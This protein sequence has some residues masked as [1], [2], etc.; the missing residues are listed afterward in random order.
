MHTFLFLATETSPL[1]TG[2]ERL[3]K[4]GTRLVRHGTTQDH[5]Q[6]IHPSGSDAP[7]VTSSV[8]GATQRASIVRPVD[9]VHALQLLA[10]QLRQ[11]EI[12]ICHNTAKTISIILDEAQLAG[13]QD[14]LPTILRFRPW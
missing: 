2:S 8:R 5:H 7:S 6:L 14:I 11:A 13:Q 4:L 9:T 10:K 12:I 3:L 1:D